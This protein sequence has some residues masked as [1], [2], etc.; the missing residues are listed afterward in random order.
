M[1]F[2]QFLG[3]FCPNHLPAPG[4]RTPRPRPRRLPAVEPLEE[5][6]LLSTSCPVISGYVYNDTNLNGVRD[7]GEGP[8]ANSP[9]ALFNAAGQVVATD[10]TDASGFYSFSTNGTVDITPKTITQT[11]TFP[12]AVTSWSKSAAVNQFNA[13][14]GTLTS[15][16]ITNSGSLTGYAKVES[17]DAAP[18][19]ITRTVS[20]V[21]TLSGPGV[22][23]L[24]TPG[25][26]SD[27]FNAPAF[28]GVLDYGGTSGHDFGAKTVTGSKTVTLNS[29]LSAYVGTGAVSFTESAS[30]TVGTASTGLNLH[31]VTSGSAN[32][33]V[34]IVYTYIPNNCLKPGSYAIVQTQEPPNHLDG[35]ESRGNVTPLPNTIGTDVIPVTVTTGDVPNNNFGEIVPAYISGFVYVDTNN[36]GIKQAGEAPIPG[37]AV[38]LS[39]S[40]SF[41]LFP[42]GSNPFPP[43]VAVTDGNG[44]YQFGP[45]Y[46]GTF[47]LVE[48]PPVNYLD[49][50]DTIGTQGGNT[51]K[52]MFTNA[53]LRFGQNGANNNFGHQLG[54][55]ITGIVYHDANNDG[56]H[57]A[58]EAVLPGTLVTLT[59]T[60]NLG[61]PVFLQQFTVGGGI[62]AFN[63]L[64]PGSYTVTET[65]PGGFLQGKNTLGNLGGSVVNDQF[66]VSLPAGV[67]GVGYNF[68][69]LLPITGT[70]PQPPIPG[71]PW[72][73]KGDFLSS[74]L[75]TRKKRKVKARARR[76]HHAAPRPKPGKTASPII[77]I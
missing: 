41:H 33:T 17:S 22:G 34:T 8:L 26:G 18:Q 29:G 19:T 70:N 2:F 28:D 48:T 9:V 75:G 58:S 25:S 74:T 27:N 66:F 43:A 16:Q 55:S 30:G 51:S 72:T 38:T 64:R 46:P 37:V 45:L 57:Q 21:F 77:R 7:P 32:A 56:V 20:G 62:Y 53:V 61:R 24:S 35:S 3:L 5:R 14:L 4:S 31:A 44:F 23:A 13:S 42:P 52:D 50:K 71:T 73:G 47:A 65:Q 40:D 15:V 76:R 1:N 60:D 54:T 69:E 59:G 10:V 36:D 49:G 63:F 12:D 67:G 11:I 6:E 68:G 39:G